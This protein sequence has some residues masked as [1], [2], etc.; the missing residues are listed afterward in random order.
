MEKGKLD[1]IIPSLMEEE[2]FSDIREGFNAFCFHY[3][4]YLAQECHTSY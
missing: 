1:R 4:I 2:G 3:S